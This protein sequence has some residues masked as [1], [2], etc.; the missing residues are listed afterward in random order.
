MCI[1]DKFAG[2]A[3]AAPLGTRLLR[4]TAL[5]VCW[6]GLSK[7]HFYLVSSK[8]CLEHSFLVCIYDFVFVLIKA[9]VI[10]IQLFRYRKQQ[11]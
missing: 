10:H 5:D 7:F 1:S 9:T 6:L 8:I 4:T 11:T 2:D 3:A